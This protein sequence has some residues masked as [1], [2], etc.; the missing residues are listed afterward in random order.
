VSRSSD[1]RR[2]VQDEAEIVPI[3]DRAQEITSEL[4]WNMWGRPDD[5][6]PVDHQRVRASAEAMGLQIIEDT[7]VTSS[8]FQIL[9]GVPAPRDPLEARIRKEMGLE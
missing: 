1:R 8:L 9:G 7:P 4:L 6:P 3:R 5:L 2:R